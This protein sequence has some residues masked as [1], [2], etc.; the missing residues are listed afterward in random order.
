MGGAREGAGRKG[1]AFENKVD[2]VLTSAG[3]LTYNVA[4]AQKEAWQAKTVELDYRIKQ[5]EYVKRDEVRQVCATAFSSL[6]QTLRSIPDMLERREGLTPEMSERVGE[7][8]DEVL[9]TIANEF[10]MLGGGDDE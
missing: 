10:E 4:R 1:K 7:V 6:T 2:D 8:I 9:D 3:E 5:G